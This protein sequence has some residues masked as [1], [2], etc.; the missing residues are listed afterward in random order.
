MKSINGHINRRPCR[1]CSAEERKQGRHGLY[2]FYGNGAYYFPREYLAMKYDE[3]AERKKKKAEENE[4]KAKEMSERQERLEY[5][6]LK[7]KYEG[8]AK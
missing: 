5:E 6:R 3:M 2:L 7:R 4:R 8:I 1:I